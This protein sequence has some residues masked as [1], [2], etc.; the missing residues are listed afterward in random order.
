MDDDLIVIL[1]LFQDLYF[2]KIRIK[3]FLLSFCHL[4]RS[5]GMSKIVYWSLSYTSTGSVWQLFMPFESLITYL[6]PFPKLR[7]VE[8]WLINACL[9]LRQAQY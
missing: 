2:L 6:S 7:D 3:Q 4:S 1:N 9:I 8:M 5:V